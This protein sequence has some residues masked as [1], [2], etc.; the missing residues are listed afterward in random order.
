MKGILETLLPLSSKT[1]FIQSDSPRAASTEELVNLAK[2]L[3]YKS[4]EIKDINEAIEQEINSNVKVVVICGSL[5]LFEKIT[6]FI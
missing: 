4:S 5:T 6:R 2:E 1:T 3:G